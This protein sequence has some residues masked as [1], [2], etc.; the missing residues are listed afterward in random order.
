MSFYLKTPFKPMPVLLI[1]GTPE[2]VFGSLNRQVGPTLGYVQSNSGVTT[3]GT[4]VFRIVSG[5]VPAVNSLITVVGCGN[6]SNF[7]TTN[8]IIL[9]ASTTDAGISTVTY[10]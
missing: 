6:S 7:N 3:T 4:L 5:N 8:S 1:Q 10:A 2:Y 9:S